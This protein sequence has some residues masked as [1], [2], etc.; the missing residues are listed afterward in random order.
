MY[1]KRKNDPK[2]DDDWVNKRYVDKK[3]N[4]ILNTETIVNED[5]C[6]KFQDGTLICSGVIE[7]TAST[8][9]AWGS[10]FDAEINVNYSFPVRFTS[11]TSITATTIDN[12]N[13]GGYAAMVSKINYNNDKIVRITLSRGTS[14]SNTTFKVSYMAMGK[15]K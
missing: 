10:I 14:V 3:I 8:F 9:V 2:Y 4:D 7:V 12:S 15:W 1:T 6:M 13:T 11:V 5:G